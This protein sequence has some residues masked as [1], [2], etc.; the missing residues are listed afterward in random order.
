MM[1]KL[2]IINHHQVQL[3]FIMKLT[4]KIIKVKVPILN[5]LIAE[6]MGILL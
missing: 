6:N 4:I 2:E 5:V 3:H 1:E